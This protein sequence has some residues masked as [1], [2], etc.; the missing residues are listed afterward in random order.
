MINLKKKKKTI[1]DYTQTND[2]QTAQSMKS[3]ENLNYNYQKSD[4]N[5]LNQ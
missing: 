3:D 1:I 2:N 4:T 5:I